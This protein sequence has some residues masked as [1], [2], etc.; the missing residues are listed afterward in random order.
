M[1]K[2]ERIAFFIPSCHGGGA[3]RVMVT[4]ANSFAKRGVLTDLVVC[5]LSG[6]YVNEIDKQVNVFDLKTVHASRSLPALL[7][8]IHD[9][10]PKAMIS[11]NPETNIFAI[12]AKWLSGKNLT[13]AV[14]EPNT[15]SVAGKIKNSSFPF[16]SF[17]IAVLRRML[18]KYADL[19]IAPSKGVA[20]DLIK[21]KIAPE[22]KVYVIYNPVD[23]EMIHDKMK[24]PVS[25]PW[26]EGPVPVILS[27]GRLTKQKDFSTLIKAFGIVTDITPCKLIIL[28]EGEQRKELET[29]VQELKLE[30]KVHMPGFVGNPFA[31]MARSSLFVLSSAWEGLPNVLIQAMACGM[32]VVATDCPS[33]PREILDDGKYG[34]LVPP[35]DPEK[36]AEAICRNL[37]R[38]HN[39]EKNN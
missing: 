17:L 6:P 27:A 14:R 34:D 18:Y 15:P 20:Y 16:K 36:L 35:G 33:G 8:Y 28:G 23:I 19:I 32:P 13:L 26:L 1:L 24:E 30:G 3:E 5:S 37:F 38:N 10:E 9:N 4:F 12:I 29:L 11:S 39:K 25:H 31:F 2:R 22:S 7:K 21:N